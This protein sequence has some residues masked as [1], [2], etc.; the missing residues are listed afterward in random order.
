MSLLSLYNEIMI[1]YLYIRYENG[2]RIKGSLYM[3][4]DDI[5]SQFDLY[6]LLNPKK[7]PHMMPPKVSKLTYFFLYCSL[8]HVLCYHLFFLP[9]F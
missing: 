2:P 9:P 4:I 6:P 3:D 8:E 5:S 1:L 7:L